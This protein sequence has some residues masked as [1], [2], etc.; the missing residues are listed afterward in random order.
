MGLELALIGLNT[1]FFVAQVAAWRWA[2]G[3]Q[4]NLKGGVGYELARLIALI[5]GWTVVG[6]AAGIFIIGL[7]GL[8]PAAIDQALALT[9]VTQ[10]GMGILYVWVAYEVWRLRKDDS[11]LDPPATEGGQ[12]LE[13]VGVEVDD[14]RVG[15]A[16]AVDD[17]NANAALSGTH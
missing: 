7:V 12:L 4:R 16:V 2:R 8:D 3:L 14:V 5:I 9:L 1:L 13:G 15:T 17:S 6:R 11:D 10:I